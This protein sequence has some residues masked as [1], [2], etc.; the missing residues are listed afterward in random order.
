MHAI[1]RGSANQWDDGKTGG[2]FWDDYEGLDDGSNGGIGG[3]GIGDTNLPHLEL[4]H[5]PF[6][7]KDGWL[8][9][10]PTDTDNDGISDIMDIDDDN[11]GYNDSIEVNE[12]TDPLNPA[13]FPDDYDK[14]LIPDSI[15]PDIDGDGVPNEDDYYPYDETQWRAKK[16]EP[17]WIA[18]IGAIILLTIG[19]IILGLTVTA[20]SKKKKKD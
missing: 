4:D 15:D 10:I 5:Y 6:M 8:N 2:N 7:E 20:I 14:D 19:V 11:D 13:S 17:N 9:Y 12:G 1:D 16:K 18:I 3:D